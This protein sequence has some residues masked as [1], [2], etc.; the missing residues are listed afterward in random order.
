METFYFTVRVVNLVL[1]F[2]SFLVLTYKGVLAMV[3][4]GREVDWVRFTLLVWCIWAAFSLGEVL[5]ISTTGGPRIVL[6][7]LVAVLTF[8]IACFKIHADE[9]N[10]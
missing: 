3:Y 1:I 5:L 2:A 4:R 8:W 9:V 6:L 10:Q 7:S